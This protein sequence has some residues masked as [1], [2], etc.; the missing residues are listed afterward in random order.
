MNNSKKIILSLFKE[1]NK[2][3]RR[4]LILFD[5]WLDLFDALYKED[6]LPK[7]QC[8]NLL[9]WD[10]DKI[11][12]DSPSVKSSNIKNI[13]R[14]FI[15]LLSFI[16]VLN[17]KLPGG[18]KK[19][20]IF[21]RLTLYFS[22]SYF[23][24]FEIIFNPELK[25]MFFN[26][27]KLSKKIDSDYVKSLEMII[28]D[29]FFSSSII[30]HR[31]LTTRLNGSCI[32]LLSYPWVYAIFLK[33][34]E[35]KAICHGGTSGEL[36]VNKSQDFE[37]KISGNYFGWGLSGKNIKQH[38]FSKENIRLDMVSNITIVEMKKEMTVVLK[39]IHPGLE[40]I[41]NDQKLNRNNLV[42]LLSKHI[43]PSYRPYKLKKENDQV[44]TSQ[45]MKPN[46]KMYNTIFIF[47]RPCCT[48]LYKCIYSEIPF[49]L[50]FNKEWEALYTKKFVNYILFLE[51]KKVLF[52]W[53][54]E[55]NMNLEITQICA[56]ISN[57][58]FNKKIFSEIQ[59]YLISE[60]N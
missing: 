37:E 22:K 31:P 26:K 3:E 45:I 56:S 12:Q 25:K 21:D 39:L 50:Y 41:T 43:K 28:P 33:N 52:F 5:F 23:K 44:F 7:S 27:I 19:G 29:I 2:S 18:V 36:L 24:Y 14:P 40:K 11:N 59:N 4:K 8:L 49:I 42:Q 1:I 13:F 30:L 38:R 53:G 58:C 55:I 17:L 46:Y 20:N 57:K 54:D 16:R 15:Y 47:D 10:L 34:L 51:T 60:N 35:I 32:A 9:E 48:F 6:S